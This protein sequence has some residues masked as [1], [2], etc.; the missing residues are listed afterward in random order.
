MTPISSCAPR[1][2]M[3]SLVIRLPHVF[4]S[5]NSHVCRTMTKAPLGSTFFWLMSIDTGR[6]SSMTV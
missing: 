4:P 3:A 1:T 6:I 5:A 2:R